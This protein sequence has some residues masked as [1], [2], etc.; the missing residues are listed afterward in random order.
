MSEIYLGLCSIGQV[1]IGRL[2][3]AWH[4]VWF[5]GNIKGQRWE[6]QMQERMWKRFKYFFHARLN[7]TL[8]WVVYLI[9]MFE[10]SLWCGVVFY[11]FLRRFR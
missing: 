1:F 9:N 4:R 3:W 7:I 6:N 2:F 5:V 8:H 10:G 11:F